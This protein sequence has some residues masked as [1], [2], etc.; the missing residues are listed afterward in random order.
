MDILVVCKELRQA[1]ILYL[2]YVN[3]FRLNPSA[4]D[5]RHL[6]CTVSL[7]STARFISEA[8]LEIV[9]GEH[10]DAKIVSGADVQYHIFKTLRRN[11]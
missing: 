11:L 3:C 7:T 1:E 6:K 4:L 10:P 2:Q 8:Q 5:R 9:Q